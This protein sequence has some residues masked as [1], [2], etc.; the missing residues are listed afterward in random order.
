MATS[1]TG[2]KNNSRDGGKYGYER[3]QIEVQ[4]LP[5]PGTGQME[6]CPRNTHINLPPLISPTFSRG[7]NAT[8]VLAEPEMYN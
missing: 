1:V 5:W 8:T 2:I 7:P 6:W 4:E 3:R